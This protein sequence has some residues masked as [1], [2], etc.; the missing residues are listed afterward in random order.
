MTERAHQTAVSPKFIPT[1]A[2]RAQCAAVF[3][4]LAD[5]YRRQLAANVPSIQTRM[6]EFRPPQ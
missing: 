1:Q 3:S 2:E 5:D 6:L 4:H